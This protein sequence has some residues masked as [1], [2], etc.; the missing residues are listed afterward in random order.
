MMILPHVQQEFSYFINL[1]ARLYDCH[2]WYFGKGNFRG[3]AMARRI[4]IA[5]PVKQDAQR[6]TG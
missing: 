6:Q 3:H 5:R 2:E 1:Q 4:K